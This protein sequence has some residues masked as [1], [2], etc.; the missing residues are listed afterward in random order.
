M[1]QK[2]TTLILASFIFIAACNPIDPAFPDP[3]AEQPYLGYVSK[4]GGARVFVERAYWVTTILGNTRMSVETEKT[5]A[6]YNSNILMEFHIGG[7]EITDGEYTLV[8]DILD[9]NKDEQGLFVVYRFPLDE[10]IYESK[11]TP[12]AKA[13]ISRN[14]DGKLIIKMEQDVPLYKTSGSGPDSITI[15]CE[16]IEETP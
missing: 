7:G 8:G 6:E 14:S 4:D 11:Q 9:L 2:Y 3:I 16:V 1:L 10:L 13:H 12:E 15:S 5:S